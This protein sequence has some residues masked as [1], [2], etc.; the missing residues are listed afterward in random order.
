MKS[1]YWIR[2]FFILLLLS[3]SY[4]SF[5]QT[6]IEMLIEGRKF[7]NSETGLIIQ[8]GY[9]SPLNTYGITFSNK[10]GVK[11]Y[12]INCDKNVASDELSM[13]LRSCM[14]TDDGSGI[15]TIYAYPKRIIVQASDGRMVYD[16]VEQN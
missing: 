7:K 16:I 10:N 2:V 13:I 5:S 11:F 12:F 4:I 8:Y 9:I 15:G 1:I 14:N 6:R 3:T